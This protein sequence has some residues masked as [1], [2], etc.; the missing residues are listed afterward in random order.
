MLRLVTTPPQDVET[1]PL[2]SIDGV[3]Y[4]IVA[5]PK[6]NVGLKYLHLAATQGEGIAIAYL[7]PKLLGTEGFLALCEYD[8]LEEHHLQFVMET[9]SK[10]AMGVAEV[11]KA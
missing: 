6:V 4:S 2:F 1:V 5:R 10:I 7:L 3:E 9:A 11:P 8:D